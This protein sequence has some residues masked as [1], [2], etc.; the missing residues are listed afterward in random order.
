MPTKADPDIR[1]KD[2]GTPYEYCCVYV[3]DVIFVSKDPMA[4]LEVMKYEYNLKDVGVPEDY[5]GGDMEIYEDGHM[6]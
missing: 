4:Y 5:L 1:M 6:A 3:D 2:C